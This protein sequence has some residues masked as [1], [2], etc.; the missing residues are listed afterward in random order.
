MNDVAKFAAVAQVSVEGLTRNLPP[1]TDMNS[2]G[3]LTEYIRGEAYSNQVLIAFRMLTTEVSQQVRNYGSLAKL[4]AASVPN[5]RND[6]YLLAESIRILEKRQEVQLDADT[7]MNLEAFK[8]EL[9]EATRFIPLWVKV[10]VAIA[11][12]LGTMIG[13]KRI[14]V[15]VGERIGKTHLSYAQGASAELVAMVDIVAA[16]VFEVPVSTTQV[17]ASGVAGTMVVN[18]S[19]LHVSTVRSLL[20][21]WI[22]T[23]PAAM[24][25]SGVLFWVFSQI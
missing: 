5:I 20:L 4:P 6:M 19:G 15:T 7:L 14:V 12:G 22:L 2:R 3:V 24:V 9:D 10:A 25:L 16:D 17:L 1:K 13:W 21:A 11:L 18:R 8:S 23:L